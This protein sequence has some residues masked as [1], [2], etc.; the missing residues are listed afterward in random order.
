MVNIMFTQHYAGGWGAEVTVFFTDN[1]FFMDLP[2]LNKY[3][4]EI[5]KLQFRS[6]QRQSFFH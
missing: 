2:T 1:F 4:C 6:L 5:P 3:I